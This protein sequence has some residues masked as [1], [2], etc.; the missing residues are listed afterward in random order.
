M[1]REDSRVSCLRL[2]DCNRSTRAKRQKGMTDAKVTRLTIRHRN[3]HLH[4]STLIKHRKHRHGQNI[5]FLH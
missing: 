2:P 5:G 4:S 1:E 3:H